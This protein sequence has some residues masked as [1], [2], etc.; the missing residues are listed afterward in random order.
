MKESSGSIFVVHW[1]WLAVAAVGVFVH[2]SACA[3]RLYSWIVFNDSDRTL[4][5]VVV[6]DP[7]FSGWP[8]E[9][10]PFSSSG[11]IGAEGRIPERVTVSWRD[12][13]SGQDYERDLKIK[14]LLPAKS[15]RRLDEI[16][17]LI[18]GDG[19][20]S[21][22]FQLEVGR[23]ESERFIPNQSPELA[24]RRELDSR[25]ATA[26]RAGDIE[27]LRA[28]AEDGARVN[29]VSL[30]DPRQALLELGATRE[31]TRFRY[32][33]LRQAI[34]LREEDMAEFLIRNGADVDFNA[35]G[36]PLIEAADRGLVATARLLLQEGA[37]PNVSYLSQYPLVAAA[38]QGH[39]EIVEVLLEAGADVKQRL[40]GKTTQQIA[41]SLGHPEAA[42]LIDDWLEEHGVQGPS[43]SLALAYFLRHQ[44]LGWSVDYLTDGHQRLRDGLYRSADGLF[45]LRTDAAFGGE[46]D[47]AETGVS[48]V[49][50]ESRID[51]GGG[52]VCVLIASEIRDDLPK[53]HRALDRVE[54]RFATSLFRNLQ[55]SRWTESRFGKTLER[56]LLNVRYDD[57]FPRNAGVTAYKEPW[58]SVG[59]SLMFVRHGRLFE[60]A[61][62]VPRAGQDDRESALG[63]AREQAL[64]VLGALEFGGQY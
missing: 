1:R 46:V 2:S 8:M 64:Q 55:E 63:A 52:L 23:Y 30:L 16:E 48:P 18:E 43:D 14:A 5:E 59:L 57:M 32:S 35:G 54:G 51:A 22:F 10:K 45:T 29:P 28:A 17:Y 4:T 9:I 61:L 38:R 26:A 47:V 39:L 25:L 24:R 34:H 42:E 15:R 33:A 7:N 50:R 53:D 49:K 19:K 56:S 6:A 41:R 62:V 60:V 11:H 3:S 27:A 21:V 20:V 37:D 36:S 58:T 44:K 40:N 12:Q 13:A 31:L